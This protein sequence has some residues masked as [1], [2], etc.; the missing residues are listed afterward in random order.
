MRILFVANIAKHILRFHLPYLKWFKEN[1]FE[2]HVAANGAEEIPWCDV[3]H[4]I[5]IERSPF[6][7][8][9]IHAHRELK[10]I[11]DNNQFVLVHGH[12][13]MGGVLA[14][15]A[16][17][18][19]RKSGTKVLYTAH[20]F[21]FYKG[22]P[23]RNW[24][25]YYPIEKFLA[26]FADGIITINQEDYNLINSKNF[27][28][29]DKH[30]INGIGVNTSRFQPISSK[31][32]SERRF[33]LGYK[34]YQF[35][36]IYVAEFIE[37]KNHRF[38]IENTA[39]LIANIPELKILFAGRGVL[40]DEMKELAVQRNVSHVV[41]FLGF[42]ND[43]EKIMSISDIGI[44]SS[45]HEGLGLNLAEEMFLGL[46]IVASHDRGHRELVVE[47]VNGFLYDQND[48]VKFVDYIVSLYKNPEMRIKFG[49]KSKKL[50]QKFSLDNSLKSMAEIYSKYL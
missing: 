26:K 39:E 50:A 4:N 12:T 9:N 28:V 36:L 41:D 46:P 40:I 33:E 20:G 35:I 24:I 10:K 32:K 47:G 44:S 21:H 43:I 49:E 37:R 8:K 25:L 15:T 16:S 23:K 17:I 27:K 11:I 30:F 7:L 34:D 19:S 13:P 18:K 31:E 29:K 45:K 42:R 22:S 3:Q 48:G 1:G 5:A 6:S 2:T 38:I 14:R